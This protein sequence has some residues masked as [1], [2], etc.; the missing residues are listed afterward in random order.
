MFFPK[1]SISFEKKMLSVG[2]L[3]YGW[4]PCC[5]P[6]E[7]SI[8]QRPSGRRSRSI[9]WGFVLRAYA[10]EL[11]FS[12]ASSSKISAGTSASEGSHFSFGHADRIQG[13]YYSL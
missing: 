7:V 10:A 9:L 2:I 6:V 3:F 11:I 4:I 8:A 5:H 12:A 13:L 1:L